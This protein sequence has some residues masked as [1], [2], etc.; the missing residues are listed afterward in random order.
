MKRIKFVGLD[1]HAEAISVAPINEFHGKCVLR[2]LGRLGP[3]YL[4]FES[5]RPW[6]SLQQSCDH[7]PLG[8][9]HTTTK[10]AKLLTCSPKSAQN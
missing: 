5:S 9:M 2:G 4:H 3:R 8:I 1:V 7:P 6:S 10:G